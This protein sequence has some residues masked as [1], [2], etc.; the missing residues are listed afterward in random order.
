MTEEEAKTKWCPFSRTGAYSDRGQ[1]TAV[2]INRDP[3][4]EVAEGCLCLASGC[5]V[6]KWG[7]E[8]KMGRGVYKSKTE[9]HCGL[10]GK[11]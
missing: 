1:M 3:R 7:V 2:S 11:P 10:A 5:A 8:I 9:G 6:W 4:K